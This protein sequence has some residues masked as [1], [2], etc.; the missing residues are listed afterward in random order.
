MPFAAALFDIDGTL[1]STGGTGG[2]ALSAALHEVLGIDEAL[3][4]FRLA[5]RTDRLIVR[6]VSLRRRGRPATEAESDAVLAR[7]LDLLPAAIAAA[8]ARY[9]VYDGVRPLLEA[10]RARGV[11][12]GL[13]T[14]NLVEGARAKLA[15]SGLLP[16]FVGAEGALVGGFGGDAEDRPSILCAGLRRASAAAGRMLAPTD[17]VVV[18]DTIF[19]VEAA[20]AVG[21]PCLAVATGP[22]SLEALRAAGADE[23]VSTLAE[24]A[25]LRPF[26]A[27]GP[28]GNA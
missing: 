7:Y 15:P 20:H 22:D 23:A 26:L 19:D 11:V 10:L 6:E 5:G 8:G 4:G 16:F 14:G 24:A 1:V 17:V 25:A 27:Q 21:C 13:G 9:R 28:P 3:D 12:V 2:A 18:G